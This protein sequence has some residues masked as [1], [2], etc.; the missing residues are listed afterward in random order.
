MNI[1]LAFILFI[2]IFCSCGEDWD[3]TMLDEFEQE[4]THMEF[5]SNSDESRR[6]FERVK[7]ELYHGNDGY[8][9]GNQKNDLQGIQKYTYGTIIKKEDFVPG[10]EKIYMFNDVKSIPNKPLGFEK[11]II[12]YNK[13]K[14]PSFKYCRYK[15]MEE[16]KGI[17][18]QK[19]IFNPGRF[20]YSVKE[21]Y[22]E[23]EVANWM[24]DLIVLL[25]F[26]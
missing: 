11:V 26:K 8:Y 10:Q 3:S 6:I 23:E 17:Q 16:K 20:N 1:R 2:F 5:I 21:N 19:S 12:T 25:S 4:T 14:G 24:I 15:L 9:M 13:E 22:T 7:K 18:A